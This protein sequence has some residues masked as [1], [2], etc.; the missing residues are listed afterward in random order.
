MSNTDYIS[1]LRECI[2]QS[3]L[4]NEIVE[5]ILVNPEDYSK[6]IKPLGKVASVN[7]DSMYFGMI[8]PIRIFGIII[9]VNHYVSEGSF[10]K[11]LK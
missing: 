1:K 9:R 7:Y 8:D 5:C 11:K 3:A 6:Y 2:D 4:N 10:I